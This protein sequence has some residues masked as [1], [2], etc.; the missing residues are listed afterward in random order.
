MGMITRLATVAS[1]PRA[2]SADAPLE[3][4]RLSRR[5]G[6]IDALHQ[7]T[8]QVAAGEI[9]A[10]LGPNGAGKSTLVRVIAGL[11]DPDAGRVSMFGDDLA[12]LP[13]RRARQMIGF[14]PSGDRSFYLRISGLE[15][16]AFFGRMHGLGR[17][18]ALRRANECLRDVG[19]SGSARAPVGTYSH[20]MQKRLS[21]ARALL[22]S[23]R[24]FLVDE[25]THD[26]DP[27]AA[28]TVRG[29]VADR[30]RRG[31]AVVW[32]TQRVDEI[33][34]FADR[35]TLIDHG[36]VRF[37]GSV[38]QFIAVSGAHRYLLHLRTQARD[39]E[40]LALAS[41]ILAPFG[42]VAPIGGEDVGHVLVSLRDGV[43]LGDAITAL[44]GA[45]V[46]VLSCR[47]ARSGVEEAFLALTGA[48][49]P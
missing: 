34:G 4:E 49:E 36:R 41:T 6:R 17:A 42:A 2:P 40:L 20:G 3:I 8:L 18:A 10:V 31:A 30:A 23:P 39:D 5:F 26:L 7:V 22:M 46:S 14:V 27:Q 43:V 28:S 37:T 32:A 44:T 12:T 13:R 47:E 33:R 24:I 25:A 21:V 1:S 29:L 16:L 19:L 45:G 11:V 15:N 35:V 38:P 48:V 9:H